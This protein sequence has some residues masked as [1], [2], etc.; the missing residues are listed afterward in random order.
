MDT[1]AGAVGLGMQGDDTCP[2]H[3]ALHFTPKKTHMG[4]VTCTV[5]QRHCGDHPWPA[6]HRAARAGGSFSQQFAELEQP[7]WDFE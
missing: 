5:F 2:P 4:Q 1:W 3:S 7:P 6:L